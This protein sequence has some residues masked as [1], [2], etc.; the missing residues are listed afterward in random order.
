MYVLYILYVP[1]VIFIYLK[2]PQFLH[3]LLYVMVTIL[4]K[5]KDGRPD[6]L[7]T[8]FAMGN[9]MTATILNNVRSDVLNMATAAS[10]LSRLTGTPAN[11]L[12]C[13]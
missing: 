11:C 1:L 12:L 4:T 8:I 2:F 7:S 9:H 3:A 5:G 13:L 10:Q 6:D